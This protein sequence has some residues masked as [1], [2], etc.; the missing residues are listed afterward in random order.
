MEVQWLKGG[1]SAPAGVWIGL[2]YQTARGGGSRR[3]RVGV[4]WQVPTKWVNSSRSQLARACQNSISFRK[5]LSLERYDQIDVFSV[6][7]ESALSD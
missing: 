7:I 1:H 2:L 4:D 5:N 3:W 6:E